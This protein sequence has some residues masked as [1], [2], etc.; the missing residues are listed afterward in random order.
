MWTADR[1]LELCDEVAAAVQKAL[2]G[3]EDWGLS[4]LRPDQYRSD[5]VADAAALD[6]L[7]RAGVGVLSE[8]SGVTRGDHPL[9]VVVDPLDGST[10]ASRGVPWYATSICAVDYQGALAA[11]VINLASGVRFEA[12]RGGGATRD[13]RRIVPSSVTSVGEAFVALNGLPPEPFGW[14]QYRTLGAAALDLCAVACGVLDGYVDCS[15]SAHGVWD[16]L[17]GLLVCQESGAHVVDAFGR[18]MVVRDPSQRRLPV[19]A[20]TTGLLDQLVAARRAFP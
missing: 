8:E 15:Q 5:L 14:Q 18:E 13:G 4:G 9:L 19:A 3:H 12:K 10:N 1:A 6:V 7:A 20:G 16:Y 17:G 11:V 2:S